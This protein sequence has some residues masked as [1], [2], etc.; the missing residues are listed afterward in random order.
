MCWQVLPTVVD[1][2]DSFSNKTGR[3][4]KGALRRAGL[5]DLPVWKL[6]GN[7]PSDWKATVMDRFRIR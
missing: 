5:G 1:Q 3:W 2:N 6:S 7:V 4:A